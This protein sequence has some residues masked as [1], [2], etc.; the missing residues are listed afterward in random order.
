[1]TPCG[2]LNPQNKWRETEMVNQKVNITK[3][4][5]EKEHWWSS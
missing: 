4:T 1:M 3:A 5:Y 2:N